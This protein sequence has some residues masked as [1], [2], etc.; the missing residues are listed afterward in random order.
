MGFNAWAPRRCSVGCCTAKTY[1]LT[2]GTAAFL[3]NAQSSILKFQPDRAEGVNTIT[4]HDASSI[5]VG[6]TRFGHSLL[7][8]WQGEVQRWA[9]SRIEQLQAEHF[10][11]ALMLQ[12]ELVIFGCGARHCFVSPALLRCLIDRRIGVETMDTSAAC[13]TYNVLAS[14]GRAVLAAMLL[15][16]PDRHRD[17]NA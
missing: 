1:N 17:G 11:Q 6:S 3:R 9:P 10:E 15:D 13:R 7:V 14:E 5:W 12:P 16:V 2:I 4:R 8:P